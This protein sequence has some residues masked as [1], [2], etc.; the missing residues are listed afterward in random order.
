MNKIIEKLKGRL[1]QLSTEER[2]TVIETTRSCFA[3][4]EPNDDYIRFL[5]EVF[6]YPLEETKDELTKSTKQTEA[7]GN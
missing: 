6:S 5:H 1:G 7:Y 3:A 4:L 2:E